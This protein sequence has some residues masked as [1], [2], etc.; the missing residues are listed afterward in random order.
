MKKVGT[1]TEGG[2]TGKFKFERL[3]HWSTTKVVV[4]HVA[5]QCKPLDFGLSDSF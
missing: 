2:E 3:S 5:R 1:G 4:G